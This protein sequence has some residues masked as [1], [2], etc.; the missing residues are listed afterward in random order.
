MRIRTSIFLAVIGLVMLMS[1]SALGDPVYQASL[2]TFINIVGPP[3][4]PCNVL[5]STGALDSDF[6][7]QL[8]DPDNNSVTSSTG[9]W[10]DGDTVFTLSVTGANAS[11]DYPSKT[12]LLWLPDHP[13]DAYQGTFVNYNYWFKATFASAAIADSG[14]LG[15]GAASGITNAVDPTSI[16]GEFSGMFLVASYGYYDF[17]FTFSGP[18]AEGSYA[19]GTA[20]DGGIAGMGPVD[21]TGTITAVPEPA[22]LLLLSTGLCGVALAAWRRRGNRTKGFRFS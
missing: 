17:D 16:D 10:T 8:Y 2:Y 12:A 13:G 4:A 9:V 3:L 5:T 11:Y 7:F 20:A 19:F 21:Y 15:N 18:D 6:Y 22:S 1:A 14:G